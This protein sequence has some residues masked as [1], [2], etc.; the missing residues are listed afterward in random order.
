VAQGD[1]L[2]TMSDVAQ[3]TG[4]LPPSPGQHLASISHE[5]R[6]WDVYLEFADDPR[7]VDSFGGVLCFSPADVD[8]EELPVRTTTILIETTFDEVVRKAHAMEEHQLQG[9]LRSALPDDD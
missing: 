3:P 9:L 8:S 5:G 4:N 7:R 2:G 1:T 6:F